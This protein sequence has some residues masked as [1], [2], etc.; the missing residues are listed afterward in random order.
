MKRK[1]VRYLIVLLLGV[2]IVITSGCTDNS[3][4]EEIPAQESVNEGLTDEYDP[5]IDSGNFVEDIDNPYFP[6]K[7]G[8]TYVYEGEDEEA[9]IN[10]EIFVTDQKKDVMGVTTTVVREREWEDGELIEDTF[11]WFAQDKDGNVWYFG[12]DSK[13]YDNGEVVSTAGS[14][15]AGVDDAKPG[16]IMKG[17]PQ[18]G[19]AYRQEYYKG[20]AEDMAEV[21]GLDGN[22]SVPYGSFEN[23]L[24]TLEWTPLEPE[25]EENKYYARDVGLLME[26]TVKGAEARLELVNITTA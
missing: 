14:W 6:L 9:A 18:I 20:E 26:E 1:P 11:D 5:A 13:E 4:S 10:V 17:D 21:L 24:V 22:V 25:V 12:E 8:T 15:E 23:C 16:I 19:D 2:L 3:G 7:P